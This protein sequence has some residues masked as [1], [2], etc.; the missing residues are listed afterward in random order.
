MLVSPCQGF[1]SDETIATAQSTKKKDEPNPEYNEEFQF[2]IECLDNRVL[3]VPSCLSRA[4]LA[5]EVVASPTVKCHQDRLN[6]PFV[7]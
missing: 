3:K 4:P 7:F 1:F 2:T 5:K 6:R